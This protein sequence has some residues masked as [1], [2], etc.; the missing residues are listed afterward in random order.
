[1]LDSFP[2]QFI[3]EGKGGDSVPVIHL[4]CREQQTTN[5]KPKLL[6]LILEVADELFPDL[7]Q[8]ASLLWEKLGMHLQSFAK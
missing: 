8:V 4:S 5:N 3:R 2:H 1:M 7:P 6:R